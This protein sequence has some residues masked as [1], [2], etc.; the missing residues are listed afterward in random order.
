MISTEVTEETEAPE[1]GRVLRSV[2]HFDRSEL[3]TQRSTLQNSGASVSS[4][5]SVLIV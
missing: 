2:R 3:S 5:T 1:V 4:V